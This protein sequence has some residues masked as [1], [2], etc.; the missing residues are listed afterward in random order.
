[1]PGYWLSL[2]T[3]T[4]GSDGNAAA[5]VSSVSARVWS[6]RWIIYLEG[7]A[8][9]VNEDTCYRRTF[10]FPQFMTNSNVTQ[11]IEGTD[12]L[13]AED[14]LNPFA[15][16]NK[17]FV[18]YCSSDFWL[19]SAPVPAFDPAVAA[20]NDPF[21]QRGLRDGSSSSNNNPPPSVS[22]SPSGSALDAAS[23]HPDPAAAATLVSLASLAG[24]SIA[25]L[26][27]ML[28]PILLHDS[29]IP[30]WQQMRADPAAD[31][32]SVLLHH[33]AADA[34]V[35]H[36]V[37]RPLV[38]LLL[39][40]PSFVSAVVTAPSDSS[41]GTA[42]APAPML[43]LDF[44]LF[45]LPFFAGHRILQAVLQDLMEGAVLAPKNSGTFDAY[46]DRWT[47]QVPQY[48]MAM[49]DTDTP[50]P[51]SSP[52]FPSLADAT[53]IVLAGSSAGAVGALNHAEFVRGFVA[54]SSLRRNITARDGIGSHAPPPPQL[55]VLSD[56][57][58]FIPY[59]SSPSSPTGLSVLS[60]LGMQHWMA[61]L[62]VFPCLDTR[63][64]VSELVGNPTSAGAGVGT[65]SCCLLAQCLAPM[66]PTDIVSFTRRWCML[67]RM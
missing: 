63:H 29:F 1:V 21:V 48:A 25:E 55:R 40:T 22:Q 15:A 62:S 45:E 32:E 64:D 46:V 36:G 65:T 56:S 43:A 30:V 60:R 44:L 7:G 31:A 23:S 59:S 11:T 4:S 27:R 61:P 13:G 24:M 6:S 47:G 41:G 9:C 51:P 54:G 18:H 5:D 42:A 33:P 10:A 34:R 14:H 39:S 12:L 16:Y 57:G 20:T 58:W 66:L 38:L 50:V 8:A 3:D 67:Q 17:V 2:A 19:G 53:D 49:D 37:A 28:R 26:K 52:F 35:G